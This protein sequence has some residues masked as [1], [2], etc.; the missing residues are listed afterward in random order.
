MNPGDLAKMFNQLFTKDEQQKVMELSAKPFD[1]KMDGL[2]EI[3][4]N[5]AR[6]PNGKVMASALRDPEIRDDMREIEEAAATGSL[7]QAEMMQKSMQLAQ[8]MQQK[9]GG[10]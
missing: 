2:A 4:E 6:I 3:F 7:G 10:M 1:E 8:K 5:S 9:F